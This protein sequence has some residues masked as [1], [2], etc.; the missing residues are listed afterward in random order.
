MSILQIIF[1]IGVT[2]G[3]VGVVIS[4]ILLGFALVKKN[5][6]FSTRQCGVWIIGSFLIVVVSV[7]A[8]LALFK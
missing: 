5:F 8:L 4:E 1:T 2:V 7:T 3:V 6:R